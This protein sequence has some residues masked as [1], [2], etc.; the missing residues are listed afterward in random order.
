MGGGGG[1]GQGASYDSNDDTNVDNDERIVNNEAHYP[2]LA[3]Q[4][5]ASHWMNDQSLSGD[6]P[7][8][9]FLRSDAES[10]LPY[11]QDDPF[12]SREGEDYQKLEPKTPHTRTH[13]RTHARTHAQQQQ[14]QPRVE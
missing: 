12:Q 8:A 9:A 2:D 1:G 3:E 4:M 6:Q 7:I 14:Q 10:L 11:S 5:N 13:T